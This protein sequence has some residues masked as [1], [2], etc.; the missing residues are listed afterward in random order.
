LKKNRIGTPLVAGLSD[1][2]GVETGRQRTQVEF[3]DR[4]HDVI[5][6]RRGQVLLQKRAQL[7]IEQLQRVLAFVRSDGEVEGES[8][9][10]SR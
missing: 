2:E 9:M 3:S 4:G 8:Q 6:E 7:A 10:L 5:L 1:G